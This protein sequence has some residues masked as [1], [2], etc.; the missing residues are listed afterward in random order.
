MG[1]RLAAAVARSTDHLGFVSQEL[2]NEFLAMLDPRQSD[3]ARVRSSVTPMGIDCQS[4]VSTSSRQ[5]IRRKLQITG[6]AALFMGRLVPIKGVDVLLEAAGNKAELQII[7]AGDG[8][9]R[10]DLERQARQQGVNARFLGWIG[11]ELRAELLQAVDVVVV[12]SRVLSDGRHEGLPLVLI[13]AL[14]AGLP[15]IASDTGAISELIEHGHSGLLVPPE[16]A[17]AVREAMDRIA[18]DSRLV[19]RLVSGGRER[20]MGR[21]WDKLVE[22]YEDLIQSRQD[23]T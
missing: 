5:A 13:E 7:V 9:L 15:V 23:A 16:N 21:N 14:A 10:S 4:L 19:D 20:A 18:S 22:L 12:P 11:P 8:P 6:F 1:N 3:K 17:E 2:R